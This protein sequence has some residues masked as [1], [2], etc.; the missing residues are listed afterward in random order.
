MSAPWARQPPPREFRP[1]PAGTASPPPSPAATS[2]PE[3]QSPPQAEDSHDITKFEQEIRALL[4]LASKSTYYELLGVTATSPPELV[5]ENFHRMARKFHP[6]RHM[7]H[8]EWLRLLPDLM[9][10]LPI[11]HQT[12]VDHKKHA[13]HHK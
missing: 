11:P 13:A 12:I 2:T 1:P 9:G 7:G 8:S 3:P 10:R 6:D 5:K 4:D